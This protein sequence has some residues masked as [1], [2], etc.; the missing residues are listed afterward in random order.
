MGDDEQHL[1]TWDEF[2][3]R[4]DTRISVEFLL[5]PETEGRVAEQV[6]LR[7]GS[8]H[9]PMSPLLED[10]HL[11]EKKPCRYPRC[12]QCGRHCSRNRY[13]PHRVCDTCGDTECYAVCSSEI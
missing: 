1:L 10:Q 7:R 9:G 5:L 11:P 2:K 4:E 12:F 6:S 13:R 3:D 8:H